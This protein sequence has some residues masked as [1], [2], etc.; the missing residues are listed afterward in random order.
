MST[1]IEL[2][3][4]VLDRIK[5]TLIG[6]RILRALEVLDTVVRQLKRGEASPLEA[7]DIMFAEELTLRESRRIKTS[8]TMARLST[9][10][11]LAG[12][13]LAPLWW[14]AVELVARRSNWAG[15]T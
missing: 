5:D 14:R 4:S 7:I 10:K 11:T 6:L 8:L 1:R 15:L 9:I 2:V 3:P 13:G 12:F